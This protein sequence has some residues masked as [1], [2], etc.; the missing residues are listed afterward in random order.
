MS[1]MRD[2][3][4]KV[5]TGRVLTESANRN[6]DP[7]SS[8]SR[9]GEGEQVAGAMSEHDAACCAQLNDAAVPRNI[10]CTLGSVAGLGGDR[11]R[12]FGAQGC[13]ET[14]TRGALLFCFVLTR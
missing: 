1:G 10:A 5:L 12:G 3:S 9:V 13:A 11:M 7:D 6:R 14:G 8:T 4:R 2:A